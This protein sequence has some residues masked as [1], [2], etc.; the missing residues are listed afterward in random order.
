MNTII[1]TYLELDIGAS[2]KGLEGRNLLFID[3]LLI[4]RLVFIDREVQA[5]LFEDFDWFLHFEL[6]QG[7]CH[8]TRLSGEDLELPTLQQVVEVGDAP[9]EAF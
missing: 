8:F 9:N 2:Q 3:H 6:V 1:N 4:C 7:V 5:V